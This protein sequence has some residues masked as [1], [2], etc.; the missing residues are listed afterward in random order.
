M[1][2]TRSLLAIP[3]LAFLLPALPVRAASPQER[4]LDAAL[5][6]ADRSYARLAWLTDRIGHRLSGSESLERAVVWG[7]GE[8]E[9][10]G[11]DRVWTEE[12]MVPHWVRGRESGAILA[13]VKRPLVLT[14]LGGSVGTPEGGV[15]G[16]VVEFS[17]FEEMQ[18]AGDRVQ[19]KIVMF[20][21]EIFPNGGR[22]HG[23]GSAVGLRHNGAREAAKQGAVAMI[24]RSLGTADFRL[25]H[26]GS[27]GYDEEGRRI[28]GA[29]VSAEDA[30]LIHRL[31]ASGEPVKVRIDLGCETL[32]DA[33][34]A[35]VLGDLR[36]RERPEEIVLIGGHLDSWD[37]GSGAHDDGAGVVA[38]MEAMRLLRSLDLRPR[39]TVRAVL[40]TN[41]ENGLRGGK[42]Y[43]EAHAGEV[44]LHV[45]AVESDS[46]GD[47]PL[48]Y[49][50]S[51]GDGAVERVQAIAAYLASID[52]TE[53]L[54]R[55]GGADISPL[56]KLGVPALNV[57]QDTTHYFDYHHT[58]ADTLDK[59]TPE[60]LARNV[61]AMA[62]LAWSLAEDP[63]PL[64]RPAP[65]E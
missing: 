53:V 28:P 34:S 15:T 61:A 48:G 65:E 30:E 35:N 7:A 4:L 52:A 44:P 3:I 20:N 41:E 42:G 27:M 18:A 16:E 60:N 51:A 13:P 33:P 43:A 8:M 17:S 6:Q 31:L 14:A 55:G 11:L 50:V 21:K 54:P 12:V 46:G 9:K 24:L 40:F 32:P 59:I 47:R 63:E 38:V 49:G 56:R 64:P 5:S 58:V 1:P 29:A 19:G 62:V 2:R 57:R 39:R 23:Y 22:E 10:D 26:T 25:A 45:A 36:G 37:V